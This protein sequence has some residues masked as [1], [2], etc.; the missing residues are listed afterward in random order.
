MNHAFVDGNKRVAFATTAVFLRIN[1]RRLV[2]EAHE[3]E[4]FLIGE[5]ITDGAD[6]ERIS[7]WIER[8]MIAS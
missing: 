8:H 6:V 7:G 3:A 1:G 5:V 2:V 4:P